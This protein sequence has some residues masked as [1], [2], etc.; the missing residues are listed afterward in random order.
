M[1]RNPRSR[2][3]RLSMTWGFL[4]LRHPKQSTRNHFPLEIPRAKR[5]LD[6]VNAE[7]R[8][9]QRPARFRNASAEKERL[10]G[11]IDE[12]EWERGSGPVGDEVD[13][14]VAVWFGGLSRIRGIFGGAV[15]FWT[16][17]EAQRRIEEMQTIRERERAFLRSANCDRCCSRRGE[18]LVGNIINFT[19]FILFS[20]I[21]WTLLLRENVF[22]S[23]FLLFPSLGVG[24]KFRVSGFK[25]FPLMLQ[26]SK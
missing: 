1:Q 24:V 6:R 17:V 8:R 16:R 10:D 9:K 23:V 7:G 18:I 2:R 14:L 11:S 25:V 12:R 26:T 15:H 4:D 19:I 22:P 20:A 21:S 13:S 3:S 5:A